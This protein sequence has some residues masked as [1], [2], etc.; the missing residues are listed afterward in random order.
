MEVGGIAMEILLGIISIGLGIISIVISLIAICISKKSDQRIKALANLEFDEKL[1]V[2]A[3]HSEKIKTNKSLGFIGTIKND[4][5]AVSN[6]Q[7][8]ADH[9]KKEEL[10]EHYIIPILKTILT[11]KVSGQSAVVVNEIIDIALKYNIATDNLKKLRQ[12]LREE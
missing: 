11:N 10:I 7:K 4:F 12:K 6:L 1:A 3:S 5:S 2:M 8:Y 9:K